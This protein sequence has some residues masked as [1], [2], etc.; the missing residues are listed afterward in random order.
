METNKGEDHRQY[1][2]GM[3]R[4]LNEFG[5]FGEEAHHHLGTYHAEAKTNKADSHSTHDG[6]FVGCYRTAE[7]TRTIV[8]SHNGL[9]A[10]IDTLRHHDE[11]ED[12]AIADAIGRHVV[13]ATVFFES[14]VDEQYH[15]TGAKVDEEWRTTD[16][17][18]R[19]DNL[20]TEVEYASA[21]TQICVLAE[22]VAQDDAESHGLRTESSDGSTSNAQTHHED[23]EIVEDSI[24]GHRCECCSHSFLRVARRT[25][26]IV[27]AQIEMR[28][29]VAQEEYLHIF[30]SVRQC[31]FASSEE[32]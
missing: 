8:V 25:N 16:A 15:Q 1:A 20:A 13:V 11:D 26:N 28:Q 12:N 23:E 10:L 27:E 21:E 31:L 18:N 7:L 32:D 4:Y 29:D 14:V 19:F 17:E 6:R 30:A 2:H 3:R 5:I 22:E 9:H 24:D